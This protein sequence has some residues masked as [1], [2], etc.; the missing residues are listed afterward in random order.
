[1]DGEEIS[2]LEWLYTNTEA[3]DVSHISRE[4]AHRV[5]NL[6]VGESTQVG[7]FDIKRIR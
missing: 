7:L 6:K 2:I 4:E 1:M 5:R 3:A